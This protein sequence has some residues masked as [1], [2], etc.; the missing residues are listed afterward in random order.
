METCGKRGILLP[1]CGLDRMLLKA[2]DERTKSPNSLQRNLGLGVFTVPV[3]SG[4]LLQKSDS[5]DISAV[6]STLSV[7]SSLR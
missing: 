7:W 6:M 5:Q 2:I 4:I 3:C 1:F